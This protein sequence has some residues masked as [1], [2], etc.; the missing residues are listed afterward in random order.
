MGPGHP[1]MI[2]P[3]VE[4]TPSSRWTN[5]GEHYVSPIMTVLGWLLFGPRPRITGAGYAVALR[6]V[7]F[8][9]LLALA[10]LLL[11]RSV[12]RRLPATGGAA[13][14]AGRG[15]AAPR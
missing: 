4:T 10:F 8:V 13:L 7:A 2:P 11:S 6:N 9:V 14:R 1:G 3:V 15:A 12:D 5:A